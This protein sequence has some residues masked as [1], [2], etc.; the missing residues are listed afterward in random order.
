MK[1]HDA[2]FVRIAV[3]DGNLRFVIIECWLRE[4]CVAISSCTTKVGKGP[5]AEVDA[6][7][8]KGTF[9]AGANTRAIFWKADIRLTWRDVGTTN[10]Y[11]KDKVAV[12]RNGRK[13]CKYLTPFR[14]LDQC[15]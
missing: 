11:S 13:S 9:V 12:C 1:P 5:E 8:G 7:G 4:Y 2:R 10:E 6:M 15:S 14:F 3:L